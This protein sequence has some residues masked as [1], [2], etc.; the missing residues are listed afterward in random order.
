MTFPP[1]TKVKL[2]N[3]DMQFDVELKVLV[4]KNK[5]IQC[6]LKN[7]VK[8]FIDHYNVHVDDAGLFKYGKGYP[9]VFDVDLVQG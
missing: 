3:L 6:S 1:T 9:I 7:G 2:Q 4:K 5:I 8:A